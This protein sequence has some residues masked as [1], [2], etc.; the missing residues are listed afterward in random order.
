MA[1]EPPLFMTLSSHVDMNKSKC[2]HEKI[3]YLVNQDDMIYARSM[4]AKRIN[5]KFVSESEPN[6]YKLTLRIPESWAEQLQQVADGEVAEYVRAAIAEKLER[7][8]GNCRNPVEEV[9]FS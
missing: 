5:G 4:K 9:A 2:R 6:K 7:E 8:I 1:S 3:A